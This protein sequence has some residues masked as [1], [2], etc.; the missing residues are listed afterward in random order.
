MGL[1]EVIGEQGQENVPA[2]IPPENPE[3]P[4]VALGVQV[5]V[6]E[7]VPALHRSLGSG[8]GT[9]EIIL[10]REAFRHY[11]LAFEEI[12]GDERY[13][14]VVGYVLYGKSWV[15]QLDKTGVNRRMFHLEPEDVYGEPVEVFFC[16]DGENRLLEC[17]GCWLC[18]HFL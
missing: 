10:D 3:C 17:F 15:E 6:A 4:G 5:G 1:F 7:V 11:L 14:P 9:H 2:G 8:A 16:P 13:L 12:N 18:Q